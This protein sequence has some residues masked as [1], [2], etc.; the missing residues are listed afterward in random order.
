VGAIW[1]SGRDVRGALRRALATLGVV[2]TLAVLVPALP[3]AAPE[4]HGTT[5]SSPTSDVNHTAVQPKAPRPHDVAAPAPLRDRLGPAPQPVAITVERIAQ[6]IATAPHSA[7]TTRAASVV[8][9]A[10][11]IAAQPRAP[12]FSGT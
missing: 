8:A 1:Q 11:T 7:F 9:A 6:P 12:P 5:G 4:P 3:T 2:A 10:A